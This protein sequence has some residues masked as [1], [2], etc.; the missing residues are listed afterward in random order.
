M[1][2]FGIIRMK[3][4]HSTVRNLPI[5][6]LSK[7]EFQQSRQRNF[8]LNSTKYCLSKPTNVESIFHQCVYYKNYYFK[9]YT[10]LNHASDVWIKAKYSFLICLYTFYIARTVGESLCNCVIIN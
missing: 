1:L 4:S 7:T 9:P 2:L 3:R 5:L 6:N 10:K 8:G